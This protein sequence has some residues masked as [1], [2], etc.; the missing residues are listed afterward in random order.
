MAQILSIKRQN[1]ETIR[2]YVD[3]FDRLNSKY[4]RSRRNQD[5]WEEI[6]PQILKNTF[7]DGLQP[8]FLRMSVKQQ[9]PK[10]L[11]EAK[12]IAVQESEDNQDMED[13]EIKEK[14]MSHKI[15]NKTLRE[16]KNYKRQQEKETSLR[17]EANVEDVTEMLRNLTLLVQ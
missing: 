7:I 15:E 14:I 5:G 3:R 1:T 13:I 8:H 12:S 16:Q 4:E 11:K 17:N 6:K 9:Y 2:D 10:S